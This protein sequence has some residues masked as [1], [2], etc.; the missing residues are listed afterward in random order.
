MTAGWG[1]L[2]AQ[3]AELG[4]LEEHFVRL[5]DVERLGPGFAVFAV[6]VSVGIGMV[7][8]LAPGHGKAIAAAYLVGSRGRTRDA[9]ALGGIVSAMHTGSVLAVGLGLY[10]FTRVPAGADRV[11]PLM[12]LVAGLLILGVGIGLVGRQIRLRRRVMAMSPGGHHHAHDHVHLLPDGVS[13]LS[14][15]G[16]V[17]L[18]VSGGLLPSP[19][20]FLVLATALFV[21]RAA[22]GL[23]LVAAFSAGLA[24]TLIAVGLATLKGRDLVARRTASSPR[25][26]KAAGLLPLV[27]AFGVLAGGA[28]VTTLAALRL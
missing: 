17:L 12:T 2:L 9:V 25:V 1:A 15:R 4:W 20:A 5:I 13:P 16:L 19:S 6:A 8:G 27:S 18:G 22:F 26:A 7:H 24:L 11:A 23:L 10:L 3:A 14:R 21:G 28:W